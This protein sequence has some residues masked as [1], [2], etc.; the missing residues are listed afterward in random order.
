MDE[1]PQSG[2]S[3]GKVYAV[4]APGE[5]PQVIDTNTYRVRINFAIDAELPDGTRISPEC[6]SV[7]PKDSDRLSI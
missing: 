3:G 2:G 7:L 6:A 4:D 1:N 5:V